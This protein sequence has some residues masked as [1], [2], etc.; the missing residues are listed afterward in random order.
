M[1]SLELT[2][3]RSRKFDGIELAFDDYWFASIALD[4][5][6]GDF[7]LIQKGC[8]DFCLQRLGKPFVQG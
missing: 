5:A 3:A 6:S 4:R 8:H 2:F 1:R 7:E